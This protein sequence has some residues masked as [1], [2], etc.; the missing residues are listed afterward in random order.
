ML[1]LKTRRQIKQA[2]PN[3]H[4]VPVEK[5][6]LAGIVISTDKSLQMRWPYEGYDEPEE[7]FE[8]I[9]LKLDPA[10]VVEDQQA[11]PTEV[12]RQRI[13][14]ADADIE[15]AHGRRVYDVLNIRVTARGNATIGGETFSAGERAAGLTERVHGWLTQTFR[16]ERRPDSFDAQG[17]EIDD[18]DRL[19]AGEIDPP[20]LPRPIAGRGPRD[21]SDQVDVPGAQ[22]D[23][24]LE[25]YYIDA[26]AEYHYGPEEAEI[27]ATHQA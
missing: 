17:N 6:D 19:Y 16:Q 20:L 7:P 26:W 1:G 22:W 11:V 14:N 25:L 10:G 18:S 4:P 23:A 3:T 27:T 13:D 5:G 12:E 8:S 21:V 9:T 24:A 15:I 2:L